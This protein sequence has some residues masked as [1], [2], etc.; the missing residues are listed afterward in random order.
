MIL[1]SFVVLFL[2]Q[3]GVAQTNDKSGP[4]FQVPA[5]VPSK[6]SQ[7]RPSFGALFEIGN[8]WQARND[9]AVPGSTGTR[10]SLNDFNQKP[11]V[12]Y[13]VYLSGKWSDQ[14]EFRLL[15]APLEVEWE[16]QSTKA[17]DFG[18]G[19]FASGQKT[20]AFYKF[21]SYR[22]TYAYHFP[23]Q[24]SWRWALG[25]TGKI[26]DAEVRLTQGVLSESKKNIGF[27]PLLHA[28]A[29]RDLAETWFVR[30]DFDGLAA[31]QGRAFD[32]GIF[33]QR[34]FQ[35]PNSGIFFGYR[36]V[37]GGADNSEVYNFAWFNTLTAGLSLNFL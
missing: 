12:S 19:R 33:L 2:T 5:V 11:F 20:L 22:L 4:D 21:N 26:R 31:P 32:L 18:N 25:F 35:N 1:W 6:A 28:Q 15:Y 37:E 7:A 30:M 36:T 34:K 13:R 16:G 27:V 17:V 24:G 8:T 23:Q 3:F 9:Q 10:F 14:H 29:R